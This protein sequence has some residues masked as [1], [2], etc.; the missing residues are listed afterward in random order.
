VKCNFRR[1]TA[2][3]VFGPPLLR[4]SLWATYNVHLRLIN[5]FK[6]VLE[7]VLRLR[8]YEQILINNRRFFCSNG[9]S[10]AQNF[11]YK[12]SSPTN[13]SSCRKTTINVLSY[14]IRMWVQNFFRFVT[15]PRLTDRQTN[16]QIDGQKGLHH[17]ARCM[18]C[19]VTVKTDHIV[20]TL[21][22]CDVTAAD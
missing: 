11:K 4:V 5:F 12:G 7:Y 16:R 10:S 17:T 15:V 9:V 8:R 2:V 1:K 18:T 3:C 19:S 22:C 14:G 20:W 13:Y 21:T 6:R